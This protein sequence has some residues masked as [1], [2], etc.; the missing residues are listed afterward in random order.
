MSLSHHTLVAWKR[1]DD[2][3]IKLHQL[4]LKAFPAVERFEL[5]SQLRR[6]AFSVAVNIVEGLARP[7]GRARVNF[8][9]ISQSSL[10][11]VGYCIHVAQRLGYVSPT[12]ASELET[13]IKQVGAP[14]AGLIRSERFHAGV[15][16]GAVLLALAYFTMAAS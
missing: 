1:A 3:F 11:E 5:G 6:A 16:V 15:K 8:L 2:L 14:L 7:A 10:A 9:D 13:E 12:I 4:S